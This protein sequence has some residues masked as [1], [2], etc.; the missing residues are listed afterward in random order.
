VPP[1]AMADFLFRR[2]RPELVFLIFS[3]ASFFGVVFSSWS[4]VASCLHCD[5]ILLARPTLPP[6]HGPRPETNRLPGCFMQRS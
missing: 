1:A 2:G 6:S 5:Q 3:G 4:P